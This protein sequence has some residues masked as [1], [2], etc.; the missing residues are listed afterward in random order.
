MT[1]FSRPCAGAL[2]LALCCAS[3]T[4]HAQVTTGTI[5]GTV[6]DSSG[7][8]VPGVALIITNTENG[9]QRTVE[10]AQ[11]GSY[12]V[13]LLPIGAYSVSAQKQ[14]FNRF[15]Q[16]GITLALNQNARLDISLSVGSLQEAVTVTADV[17]LVE[18]R[19]TS[20]GEVVNQTTI[21]ELPL[22]GRNPIQ[23]AAYTAGVSTISAP[24]VLTWTGRNGGQLTVHG[25]RANENDFMLDGQHMIGIYQ[26][27][28]LNYPSPDSLQEF[29][30]IT[31]AYSAEFGRAAGSVFNAVTK[32]GTNELHGGLWEFLRNDA[33]NAR[34]FFSA[35]V[36][37]L[38]QNQFGGMLG[39]PIKKDKLFLFGTYQG[40]RIRE[41]TIK[42]AFPVTAQE[43]QGFF[44][45]PAG[46]VLRNPITGQPFP[47][48]DAS[49]NTYFVDPSTFNPVAARVINQF[50]PVT[51]TTDPYI[52]LASRP[53]NND[54]FTIKGDANLSS[55]NRLTLSYFRD[56]TRLQDPARGSDFLNYSPTDNRADV[57]S[58]SLGDTH[59][60]TPTLLNEVRLHYMRTYDFWDT[61]NH[62]TLADLG[63]TNWQPEGP[64]LPP[65]FSVSSRFTLGAGGLESLTELGYRWQLNETMTKIF[66]AHSFKYGA[67]VMR[68][69]WGI[70]AFT[71][72]PG[73]FSFTGASTNDPVVDFL[74]GRPAQLNRGTAIYKDHVSWSRA[75]FLQDDWRVSRN[76]TLNLGLRYEVNPPFASKNQRGT[77]FR[78]GQKSTLVPGLPEGLVVIGDPGVYDT[79]V[80]IDKNNF[81]PR[82][83]LAWDPFGT[84]KTSIR[85][86]GGIFYGISDPDLTSQPGSNPPW[87]TRSTVLTPAGGL[88]DPFLGLT[89]PFPY[90]INPQNPLLL[91]PQTVLDL[92]PDYRD[93]TVWSWTFSIQRQLVRSSMIE[94]AY[95]GKASTGLAMTI[96]ANPALPSST[97]TTGNIN[98]RR[99]YYP[100]VISNVNQGASAGHSSYHGLDLTSRTRM[101]SGAMLILTY[102]YS[103]SLD[104]N[105]TFALNSLINQNPFDRRADK[106]VSSFDRTHV[107]AFAGVYDVPGVSRFFNNNQAV[108]TLIDGW[109]ISATGRLATGAPFNVGLGTDNSL[110][111]VNQDR[112]DVIGDMSLPDDRTRQEKILRW[113]NPAAFAAP[114]RGTFGNAGR[115]IGRAPGSINADLGLF[116]SFQNPAGERWGRLQFRAELFNVTN[117]VNLGAPSSNLNAGANFGRI[118][119]AGSPRIVQFALKYLF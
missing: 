4:M 119:S 15:A 28:G 95:I 65:T 43:R 42:S 102:T 1:R 2:V 77:V 40:L 34:N 98:Q 29:R 11:D 47:V 37:S 46:R 27:T 66:R 63:A 62:Q 54:Q 25:S 83:G 57:W 41:Q 75:F 89:Q 33:L 12:V 86:S 113:F 22:N 115:N 18:T 117:R 21:T 99:L 10:T 51:T 52:T 91:L 56:R 48:V 23:L 45:E 73:N 84:G 30:L 32:S 14:G 104:D 44:R 24:T 72:A 100:G 26:N 36:P 13:P 5:L 110:T 106:A 67:E 35:T 60:F 9:Y 114:A 88:S 76:L 3:S 96:S 49:T 70:R 19:N 108:R 39:G 69:H 38:R 97:A 20:L 80:P 8:A 118:T 68:S 74:L 105:S 109:Q 93:P 87:A 6:S 101:R 78:P 90:V 116:K 64:P 92:A 107:F 103:K 50:V 16:S 94:A 71:N 53:S 82:V 58:A 61:T 7:A 31:S 17:P 81:A 112:P 55:L 59:S 85:A 111:G 79:I